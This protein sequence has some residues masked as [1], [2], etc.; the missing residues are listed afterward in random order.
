MDWLNWTWVPVGY[1]CGSIPFA[2][3]LGLMRGVDV[4]TIGSGNVGATNLSRALGRKWGVEFKKLQRHRA[5]DDIRE[6]IAELGFYLSG[7]D[8]A[9]LQAP[10]EI[11]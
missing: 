4:R 6:S 5:L 10:P 1:V 7:F 3:L 2:L 8:P 11:S 9:R